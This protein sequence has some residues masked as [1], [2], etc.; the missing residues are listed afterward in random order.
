MY[1]C[2]CLLAI[3]HGEDHSGP[4]AN[5]VAPSKDPG[6]AGRPIFLRFDIPPLVKLEFGSGG[7]QQGVG[8]STEGVDDH[9]GLE[10]ENLAIDRHRAAASRGVRFAELHFLTAQC[11]GPATLVAN[12]FKG[13]G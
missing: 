8:A 1:R 4:P 5:D 7:G 13:R 9:V 2:S 6:D 3:P 12:D 11:L 10:I